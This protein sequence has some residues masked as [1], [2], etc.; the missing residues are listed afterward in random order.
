[1]LL[2]AG[3]LA[4][5]NSGGTGTEHSCGEDGGRLRRRCLG[6]AR[7]SGGRWVLE[8]DVLCAATS[9][10]CTLNSMREGAEVPV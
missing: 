7:E 10:Q 9:Y 5:L 1:M 2:C 6:T 3:A 8:R 4:G